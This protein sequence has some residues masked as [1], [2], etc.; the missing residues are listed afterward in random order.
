MVRARF[1]GGFELGNGISQQFWLCL[2]NALTG[3]VPF[4]TEIMRSWH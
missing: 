1:D 2:I 3:Q 4:W